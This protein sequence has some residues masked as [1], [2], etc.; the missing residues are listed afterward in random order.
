M[1][2]PSER[3]APRGQFRLTGFDCY[4][5]SDYF[6]GDHPDLAPAIREARKRAATPNGLP[7]SFSDIYYVHDHR[8]DCRYRVTHDDLHPE[9]K[10]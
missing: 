3:T 7:T 5:Y 9:G 2:D 4:D 6:L 10:P 8:G 1:T